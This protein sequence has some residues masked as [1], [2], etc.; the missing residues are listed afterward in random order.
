MHR[1][2]HLHHENHVIMKRLHHLHLL[3]PHR[4]LSGQTGRRP[5][6]GSSA[7][8]STR[9]ERGNSATGGDGSDE[10][11]LVRVASA[12]PRPW[13]LETE[14]RPGTSARALRCPTGSLRAGVR[15]DG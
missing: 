6:P 8:T 2:E 5:Q 4:E 3:V 15:R 12:V 10:L 13:V 1:H 14:I 7:G 11:F 9:D